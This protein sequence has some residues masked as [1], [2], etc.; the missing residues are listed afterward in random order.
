MFF[1]FNKHLINLQKTL[2]H[3]EGSQRWAGVQGAYSFKYFPLFGTIT[4]IATSQQLYIFSDHKNVSKRT[5]NVLQERFEKVLHGVRIGFSTKIR[6]IGVGYKLDFDK[7]KQELVLKLG[8]SHPINKPTP[9]GMYFKRLNDRSSVYL[10]YF[11][12][13]QQLNNFVAEIKALRPI[14]PYKGKGLRY[15]N[16]ITQRKEG[17]KSNL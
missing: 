2:I 12:D 3:L 17:K 5:I 6:A 8:Y 15:I 11:D 13:K 10:T 1:S 14:E 4:L 7:N 9:R 16:E